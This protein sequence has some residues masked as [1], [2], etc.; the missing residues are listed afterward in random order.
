MSVDPFASLKNLYRFEL[1]HVSLA[2]FALCFFL[3]HRIGYEQLM[4]F[5]KETSYVFIFI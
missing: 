1:V 4:P 3:L 2:A 5:Y